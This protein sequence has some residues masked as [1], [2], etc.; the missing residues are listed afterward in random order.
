MNST[1]RNQLA[2]DLGAALVALYPDQIVLAGLYGSTAAGT[3]TAWSDLELLF[4]VKA[5]CPLT[6]NHFIVRDIAVGYEVFEQ[7][8]LETLL[9]EPTLRWPFWMGV[10]SVL[11]VLHGDPAQVTAWLGLG[12]AV[13]AEP[14]RSLLRANLPSLVWESYGRIL[15]CHRRGNAI[16][17]I[18]A[19][20]EVLYEMNLALCLLNQR[21]VTHDYYAGLVDAFAFPKLP[22]GYAELVPALSTA[23]EIAAIVPLATQLVANFRQLLAEEGLT[24]TN[25]QTVH[26][27]PV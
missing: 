26:D 8:K 12:Q 15:S 16:D 10:L 19:V 2:I 17:T 3:D 20:L 21:W 14:F 23:T 25:Y 6:G 18:P 9:A 27:L 7:Q 22:P 4:V 13:P 5:G 24:V 1:E 11:K